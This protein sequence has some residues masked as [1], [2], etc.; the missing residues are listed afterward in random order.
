MYIRFSN[1]IIIRY[2][3]KENSKNSFNI[4]KGCFLALRNL[5]TIQKRSVIFFFYHFIH[6]K[7]K[8]KWNY[9]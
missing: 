3:K 4:L 6:L 2:L 1:I 8:R 9:F 7:N 5:D